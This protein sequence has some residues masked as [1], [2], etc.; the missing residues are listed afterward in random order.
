MPAFRRGLAESPTN[1]KT[2][3][4]QKF[5]VL[6]AVA[7]TGLATSAFAGGNESSLSAP[8]SDPMPAV[9]DPGLLGQSYAGLSYRYLDLNGAA[10][11]GD[12]YRFEFNEALKPGYDGLLSFD[13]MDAG[14][15]SRSWSISTGLRASCPDLSWG[16]PYAEAGVGYIQQKVAG[17]TD[18]SFLWSV[19]VGAEFHVARAVTVT[20]YLRYDDAPSLNGNGRWDFGVKANY[21]IDHQWSVTV[22]IDRDDDQN[23]GFMV[24]TN[25]RY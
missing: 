17:A 12:V 4:I 8:A 14:Q 7:A 22:G 16:K 5:L 6:T 11:H 10:S 23:N 24:G 25:F 9:S 3:M 20:P 21:W 2:N 13:W 1:M 18:D 15:S 19:A